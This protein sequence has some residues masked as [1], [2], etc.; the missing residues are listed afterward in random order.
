MCLQWLPITQINLWLL[1]VIFYPDLPFSLC[2]PLVPYLG[3]LLQ[4][5]A[6][7]VVSSVLLAV[8]FI[9]GSCTELGQFSLPLKIHSP[10]TSTCCVFM[11]ADLCDWHQWI[12]VIWHLL[13]FNPLEIGSVTG[14]WDRSVCSPLSPLPRHLPCSSWMGCFPPRKATA[15]VRW[16]PLFFFFSKFL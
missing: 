1:S 5:V 10:P 8:C 16:S 15:S 3:L 13:G 6:L 11:D 9:L 7:F 14:A 2:L 12:L 4:P